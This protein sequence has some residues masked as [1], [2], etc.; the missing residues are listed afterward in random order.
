MQQMI[1]LYSRDS[2]CVQEYTIIDFY[3]EDM[4]IYLP[5]KVITFKGR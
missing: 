4:R 1:V 3:E 5:E 2:Q